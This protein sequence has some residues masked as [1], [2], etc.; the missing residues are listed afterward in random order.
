LQQLVFS[1]ISIPAA[2]IG[3]RGALSKVYGMDSGQGPYI[4]PEGRQAMRPILTTAE[5][6][7]LLTRFFRTFLSES[8]KIF[9][10]Y[11]ATS[12]S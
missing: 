9:K 1:N 10:T 12:D 2:N 4:V 5:P 3:T 8:A 11:V 7:N 6:G